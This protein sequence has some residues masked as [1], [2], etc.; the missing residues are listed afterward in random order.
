MKNYYFS[1]FVVGLLQKLWM[2]IWLDNFNT[3]EYALTKALQIEMDEYYPVNHV[4]RSIEKQLGSMQ[5]STREMRLKGNN[6]RCTK[7]SRTGHKK[8]YYRHDDRR[9]DIRFI[10]TKCFCDTC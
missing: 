10:K 4:N 1:G 2:H 8:D 6:V 5:K 7:C 9:Q 3:Y